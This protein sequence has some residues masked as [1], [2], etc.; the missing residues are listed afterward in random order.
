MRKE[1]MPIAEGLGFKNNNN[2]AEFS[3]FTSFFRTT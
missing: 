2:I 1:I 3:G